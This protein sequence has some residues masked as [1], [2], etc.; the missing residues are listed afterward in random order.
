MP[1]PLIPLALGL[2]EFAPSIIKWIAGEKAGDVAEKVVGI[3]TGV[4]GGAED[5]IAALRADPALQAQFLTQ[6]TQ[7]ELSLYQ[8]E[9]RRL[10]IVNATIRAEA[11]AGDAYVRRWRPTWGYVTAG[12]WALQA[13][14]LFIAVGGATLAAMRGEAGAA[15][16]LLGGLARMLDGMTLVWSVAL[17]VLGVAVHS[18]SRDKAVAAGAPPKP[19]LA[20]ALAR[21]VGGGKP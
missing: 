1:F 16:E 12:A 17:T 5:P 20:G 21:L 14:A 6:W 9:T 13:V 4:T 11:S 8:E 3:A 2:A 7:L 15:A 10:E 18:R 19:G